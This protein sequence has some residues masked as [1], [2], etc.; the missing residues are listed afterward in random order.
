MFNC[1]TVNVLLKKKNDKYVNY[2]KVEKYILNILETFAKYVI[3]I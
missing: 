3:F 1:L 2:V